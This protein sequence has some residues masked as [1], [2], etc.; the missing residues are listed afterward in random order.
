[1]D[2]NCSTRLTTVSVRPLLGMSVHIGSLLGKGPEPYDSGDD[3]TGWS[4]G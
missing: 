2:A 4:S 3:V 1:M